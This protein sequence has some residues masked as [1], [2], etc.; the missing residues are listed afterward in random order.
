TSSDGGATFADA[1]IGGPFDLRSAPLEHGAY[2][3]GDY[4]ALV[5]SGSVFLPFF[6]A[7]PGSG[8]S[9]VFFRPADAATVGRG[10][11]SVARSEVQQ[12]WRGARERWRFGTLFK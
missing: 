9:S 11:L 8:P 7:V 10:A 4:Q 1:M 2:F 12:L 6:V 5:S 3:L